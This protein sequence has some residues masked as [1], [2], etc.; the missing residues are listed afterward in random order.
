MIISFILSLVSIFIYYYAFDTG[1]FKKAFLF[2]IAIF[3]INFIIQGDL[4][5]FSDLGI[6]L[7]IITILFFLIMLLIVNAIEYFIYDHTPSFQLYAICT[8]LAELIFDYL[9]SSLIAKSILLILAS[10]GKVISNTI[11][12]AILSLFTIL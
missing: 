1:G 7:I 12:E 3:A 4:E 5:V 10:S 6:G 9:Y 11:L 8:F 2:R